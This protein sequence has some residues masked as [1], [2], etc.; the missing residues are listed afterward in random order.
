MT[1][2]PTDAVDSPAIPAQGA[3][4]PLLR[5]RLVGRAEPLFVDTN[6][7]RSAASIWSGAQVW[8]R[9]LRSQPEDTPVVVRQTDRLALLQL[10]VAALWDGRSLQIDTASATL[11]D[12]AWQVD[13]REVLLDGQPVCLL[14][15]G[16]WPD[17]AG[18]VRLSILEMLAFVPAHG[19]LCVQGERASHASLWLAAGQPLARA[20]SAQALAGAPQPAH[21]VLAPFDMASLTTPQALLDDA[22]LPLLRSTEVWET[23]AL[24]DQGGG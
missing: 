16:G 17:L 23:A 22:L 8:A 19:D 4:R 15:E 3:W 18:P 10:L 6:G 2:L 5:T 7:L 9:L 14:G 24:S 11:A 13:G 12:A 21:E 1:P 20:L